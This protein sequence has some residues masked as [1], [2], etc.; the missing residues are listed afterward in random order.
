MWGWG[1]NGI[2]LAVHDPGVLRFSFHDADGDEKA[3]YEIEV[4]DRRLNRTTAAT[5]KPRPESMDAECEHGNPWLCH[6]Q[7]SVVD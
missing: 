3:T 2:L 6:L 1:F 5:V 4:E 7:N